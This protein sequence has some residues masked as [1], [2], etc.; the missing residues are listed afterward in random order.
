[1]EGIVHICKGCMPEVGKILKFVTLN[2]SQSRKWEMFIIQGE[3]WIWL[4]VRALECNMTQFIYQ[5]NNMAQVSQ[6]EEVTFLKKRCLFDFWEE[7]CVGVIGDMWK[8][9]YYMSV[10]D[11]SY[12]E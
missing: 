5:C 11:G 12:V 9:I 4:Q 3:D 6:K 8:T 10:Y 2:D 1:M 7:W